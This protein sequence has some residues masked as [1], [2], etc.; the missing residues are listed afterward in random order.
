MKINEGKVVTLE[1]QVYDNNT[2]ELLEDTKEVGPFF[3]IQG[4]G[5]FIPKVEEALEG[6]EAGFAT[7]LTLTPEEGYG[8][9]DEDFIIEMNKGDF[10]EFDDIY[11]GLDFI[12][13]LEDGT[14]Q[15]FV[16][17]NIEDEVVTADG[18]HPFAGKDLRFEVKVAGVRE[19]SEE[20]IEHGHAHFHGFED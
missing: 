4:F 12:A 3:Y 2:N 14:E 20:E 7:T 1:F 18:N 15:S 8:E 10:V 16:I 13:D 17:T 19:A 11:E 5:N 9:Y 6:Q